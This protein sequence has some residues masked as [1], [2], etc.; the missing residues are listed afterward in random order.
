[1]IVERCGN[2]FR[3]PPEPPFYWKLLKIGIRNAKGI[4]KDVPIFQV[5]G[6]NPVPPTPPV[7]RVVFTSHRGKCGRKHFRGILAQMN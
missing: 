7:F 6:S 5:L 2:F 3:D 4:R 1:M